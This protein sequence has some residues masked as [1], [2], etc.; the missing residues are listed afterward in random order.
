MACIELFPKG[1]AD[2]TLTR[3]GIA[4]TELKWLRHLLQIQ[5]RR[6]AK[7]PT[8][9]IYMVNRLIHHQANCWECIGQKNHVKTCL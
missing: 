3:K 1:R 6:F 9:N 7:H 4:P 2:I 5:Y 8:F